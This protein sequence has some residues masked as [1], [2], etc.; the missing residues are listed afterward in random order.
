LAIRD[1]SPG[2]AGILGFPNAAGYGTKIIDCGISRHTGNG[3]Y[4]TAPGRP[5]VAEA[6][7]V[8][9]TL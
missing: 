2:D 8:E 5:N 1:T 3:N 7:G 9:R 4:T 6:D